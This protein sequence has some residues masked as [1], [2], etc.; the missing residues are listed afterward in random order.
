[1]SDLDKRYQQDDELEKRL[2]RMENDM[3]RIRND[4]HFSKLLKKNR[5]ERGNGDS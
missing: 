3:E 2:K 4:P 1:M 5:E